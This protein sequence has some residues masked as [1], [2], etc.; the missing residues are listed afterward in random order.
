M[1]PNHIRLI[2]LISGIILFDFLFYRQA[3]GM[4]ALLFVPILFSLVRLSGRSAFSSREN[5]FAAGGMLAA[6]LAVALYGSVF[7]VFAY[8]GAFLLYLGFVLEPQLRLILTAMPGAALNFLFAPAKMF[9]DLA[10]SLALKN[11]MP[12]LMKLSKL[13][14]IPLLV[15]FVFTTIYRFSN[16]L[17][18][19][20]FLGLDRFF[21]AFTAW[22][23]QYLSFGHIVFL[24]FT[25]ILVCGIVYKGNKFMFLQVEA[26]YTDELIRR[27]SRIPRYRYVQRKV[28]A[29]RDEYRMGMMLFALLNILLLLVNI[30]EVLWLKAEYSQ[31]SAPAMSQNLHEGTVLLI[32]SIFLSILVILTFFRKNLNFYPGNRW[33][34][35]GAMGWIAQNGLMALNVGMRN[36]FYISHYGLTYK[37]I[38]VLYFLLLVIAGLVLLLI[39]IRQKKSIFYL[40]RSNAWSFYILFILFSLINWDQLI[41]N[42][43]LRT[44]TVKSPDRELLMNLPWRTLKLRDENRDKICPDP[45]GADSTVK[46]QL[47]NQISRFMSRQQPMHW[48]SFNLCDRQVYR[49]F[50]KKAGSPE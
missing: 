34:V 11:T 42:C 44:S 8:M 17:F 43:N 14:I 29:L 19:E 37:R 15:L 2:S 16:P 4:N 1:K 36:W 32:F 13:L 30:S 23:G 18:N 6:G 24:L 38:G 20:G 27:K 21:Q 40:L 26:G 33:L 12:R 35:R 48:Q 45:G 7:S 31:A 41:T 10:A 39:K 28:N 3:P 5:R 47:N 46:K 50:K 25:G 49:Y 9:S 22:L